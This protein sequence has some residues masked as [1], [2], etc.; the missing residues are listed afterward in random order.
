MRLLRKTDFITVFQMTPKLF[1]LLLDKI[2]ITIFKKNSFMQSYFSW[3]KISNNFKVFSLIEFNSF[4]P[5]IVLYCMHSIQL[6]AVL[7]FRKQD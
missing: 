6:S 1:D 4:S 5:G 7:R 2:S 3:G